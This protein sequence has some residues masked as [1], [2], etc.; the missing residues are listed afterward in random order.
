ME[1]SNFISLE[2]IGAMRKVAT[3]PTADIYAPSFD[4][5]TK[6]FFYKAAASQSC[7]LDEKFWRRMERIYTSR[8]SVLVT[9]HN[10]EIDFIG[11]TY[12][13]IFAIH[14]CEL[15]KRGYTVIFVGEGHDAWQVNWRN[16]HDTY[17]LLA[18]KHETDNLPDYISKAEIRAIRIRHKRERAFAEAAECIRYK[19]LGKRGFNM[20]Y[21]EIRAL[22]R[23]DLLEKEIRGVVSEAQAIYSVI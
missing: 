1:L 13:R 6:D 22:R 20:S 19:K 18:D 23:A 10:E 14:V 5:G 15:L 11:I 7:V 8:E 17:R 21:D 4:G 3:A 16:W 9:F 2:T 12:N